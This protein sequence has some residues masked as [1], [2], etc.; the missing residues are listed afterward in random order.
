MHLIK[1][2]ILSAAG[3]DGMLQLAPQNRIHL[4]GIERDIL[5]P[6]VLVSM[7]ERSGRS[8][9]VCA[10]SWDRGATHTGEITFS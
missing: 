7:G 6:L 3:V 9:L 8:E 2:I 5:Q 1:S 4:F 10:E